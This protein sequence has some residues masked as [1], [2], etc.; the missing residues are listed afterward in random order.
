MILATN[1]YYNANSHSLNVW[2]IYY[3]MKIYV[4]HV[5]YAHKHTQM[6]CFHVISFC[7]CLNMNIQMQA[8]KMK[9]NLF[10][11]HQF[12]LRGKRWF[13]VTNCRRHVNVFL[14]ASVSTVIVWGSQIHTT[15][16]LGEWEL[17]VVL[18]AR[19]LQGY[20]PRRRSLW[21]TLN[22]KAKCIQNGFA[23]CLLESQVHWKKKQPHISSY[24]GRALCWCLNESYT[25]MLFQHVLCFYTSWY[26][27]SQL[28]TS[29][30]LVDTLIFVPFLL[31]SIQWK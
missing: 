16:C 23:D 19:A 21:N 25:C 18:E 3:C 9:H 13:D 20:L 8:Y 22:S 4:T 26:D 29:F 12:P 15:D 30:H 27:A 5:S 11:F 24:T 31:P 7:V 28:F 14:E 10:L 2:I 6:F 1:E 17:C